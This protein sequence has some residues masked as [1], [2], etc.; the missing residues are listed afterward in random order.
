MPETTLCKVRYANIEVDYLVHLDRG[1]RGFGQYFIPVV[2]DLF[3]KVRRIC[4]FASGPGFIG[5]SLLANGLCETLSLVEVNP[6]WI[7]VCRRT[8]QKTG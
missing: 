2:K 8:I 5:F 7:D 3:G 6:E 4:E 1:G